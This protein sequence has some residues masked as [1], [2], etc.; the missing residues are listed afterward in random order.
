MDSCGD[1]IEHM[2]LPSARELKAH[3]LLDEACRRLRH[4]A[5]LFTQAVQ[6]GRASTLRRAAREALGTKPLLERARAELRAVP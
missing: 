6:E 2:G 5:K 4:A 1:Q 3:D